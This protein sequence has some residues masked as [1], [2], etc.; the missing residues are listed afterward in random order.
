MSMTCHRTMSAYG[1]DGWTVQRLD[2]PAL[3]R[4]APHG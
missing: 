4:L 1:I 3:R 2:G